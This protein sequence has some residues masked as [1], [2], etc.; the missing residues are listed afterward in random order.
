MRVLFKAVTCFSSVS[1]RAT[2]FAFV[3]CL[4]P[5]GNTLKKSASRVAC[6]EARVCFPLQTWLAYTALAHLRHLRLP[7]LQYSLR[8]ARPQLVHENI[9][10]GRLFLPKPVLIQCRGMT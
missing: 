5:G 8:T 2:S 7:C 1:W 9:G 6:R 10:R 3:L 4:I